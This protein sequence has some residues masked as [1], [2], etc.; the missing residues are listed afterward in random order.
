[1]DFVAGGHGET[2]CGR[3][4][5]PS[6]RSRRGPGGRV[7]P[8]AAVAWEA[9]AQT[10]R[11]QGGAHAGLWTVPRGGPTRLSYAMS[12]TGPS[13]KTKPGNSGSSGTLPVWVSTAEPG[14]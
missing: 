10:L 2:R 12:K 3:R 9:S 13:S 4:Y 8:E 11:L 14:R 1:M 7:G 5:G 6:G